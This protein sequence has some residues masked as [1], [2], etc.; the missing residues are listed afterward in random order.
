MDP[1]NGRHELDAG[2][3][4]D[5]VMTDFVSFKLR[6]W[7]KLRHDLSD[8]SPF[9]LQHFRQLAALLT[10]RVEIRI[11]DMHS[12]SE[13]LDALTANDSRWYS[14]HAAR[15]LCSASRR[16]MLD[17]VFLT[18]LVELVSLQPGT[19]TMHWRWSCPTDM[20]LDMSLRP[21][22]SVYIPSLSWLSRMDSSSHS[23][24][25]SR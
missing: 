17:I 25:P 18:G 20:S 12:R 10:I 1:D 19:W 16:D 13:G 2:S 8:L 23:K 3:L 21:A 24:Q 15:N 14:G 9:E 22:G 5:T 4:P 6:L 7:S 11:Q